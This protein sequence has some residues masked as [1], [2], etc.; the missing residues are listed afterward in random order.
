MSGRTHGKPPRQ[1]CKRWYSGSVLAYTGLHRRGGTALAKAT[2]GCPVDAIPDPTATSAS[3]MAGLQAP[4]RT[5]LAGVTVRGRRRWEQRAG[6]LAASVCLDVESSA[7]AQPAE[8]MATTEADTGALGTSCACETGG[9]RAAMEGSAWLE[10]PCAAPATSLTLTPLPDSALQGGSGGWQAVILTAAA[11]NLE[12]FIAC[13]QA[14]ALPPSASADADAVGNGAGHK[15]LSVLGATEPSGEVAASTRGSVANV[16]ADVGR[17]SGDSGSSA[18]W[19]RVDKVHAA[20]AR[21]GK[22]DRAS[23]P[24]EP[25][26][27]TKQGRAFSIAARRESLHLGALTGAPAPGDTAPLD[28][29]SDSMP[30]GEGVAM[31]RGLRVRVVKLVHGA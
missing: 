14:S 17:A 2:Q 11:V 27:A 18:G 16:H 28:A 23:L 3:V 24:T 31:E 4:G 29:A 6:A 12:H 5:A 15:G 20:A 1:E 10:V 7:G 13:C 19:V 26:V 22:A 30:R 8:A 25:R 21:T 9:S